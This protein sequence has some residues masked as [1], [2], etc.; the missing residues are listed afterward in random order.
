MPE[1][2]GP[3]L[4]LPDDLAADLQAEVG[5]PPEGTESPTEPTADLA[6]ETPAA[7]GGAEAALDATDVGEL[8]RQIE[9]AKDRHLRALAEFENYKR[10]TLREHQELRRFAHEA[11]VKEL[12]PTVDNLERALEH[13]RKGEEGEDIQKLLEGVELT[14]RSLLK[15]LERFGVKPVEA[16]GCEFDPQ[17]HEAI[18]RV[19][20]DERAPN[21]VAEVFQ[22]GYQLHDRLLRPALVAVTTP[23]DKEPS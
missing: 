12:L 3:K 4:E 21:T 8:Q 10:R 15:V 23:A 6:S 18:R 5:E 17:I 22:R 13:A 19:S 2:K 20:S 1:P 7:E 9:E 16:E 11:L 14:Y